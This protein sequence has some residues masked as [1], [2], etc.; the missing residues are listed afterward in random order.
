MGSIDWIGFAAATLT[1]SALVPQAWMTWRTRKAEGV[2]LGMYSIF[3]TGV[4][5]WL[6]YGLAIGSWPVTLANAITLILS[7]FII[8]MKLRFK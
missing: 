6:V 7:L 1:T 3:A 4:A 5:L 2:S 8:A